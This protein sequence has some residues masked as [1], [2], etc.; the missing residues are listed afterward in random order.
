MLVELTVAGLNQFTAKTQNVDRVR[1][2]TLYPLSATMGP[3]PRK[4]VKV[5]YDNAI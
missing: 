4:Q 1:V 5:H 2:Y 3:D